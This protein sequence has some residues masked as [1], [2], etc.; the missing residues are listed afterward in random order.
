MANSLLF[1]I[2][3]NKQ[4]DF[5]EVTNPASSLPVS[6]FLCVTNCLQFLFSHSLPSSHYSGFCLHFYSPYL[7]MSASPM[8]SLSKGQPLFLILPELETVWHRDYLFSSLDCPQVGFSPT[9]LVAS[10]QFPL[11]VVRHFH[12][13]SAEC[14][15]S[16]G[17]HP[18]PK[19]KP[20]TKTFL[21]VII[22]IKWFQREWEGR[23]RSMN[24]GRRESQ[25]KMI[26][27]CG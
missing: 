18:N 27:T 4:T 14:C 9:S 25:Q 8:S 24:Q 15:R 19:A 13:A 26:I 12:K 6:F 21:K 20:E 16:L 11:L 17:S 3:V 1:L 7:L 23:L 2:S 5:L 10:S 22:F